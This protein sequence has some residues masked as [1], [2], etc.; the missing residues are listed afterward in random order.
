MA[1]FGARPHWGK[2]HTVSPDYV[3]SVY[4]KIDEFREMVGGRDPD[5]KFSNSAMDDLLRLR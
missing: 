1:P 4:P 2:V 5:G 3:A